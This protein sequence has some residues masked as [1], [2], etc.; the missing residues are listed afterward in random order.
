MNFYF[1]SL[2][3]AIPIFII[4][5]IVE[6]IFAKIKGIK[7]NRAADIISSQSSGMT[8]IIFDAL[9]FSIAIISYSWL[10]DK[11]AIIH[12]ELTW[13]SF[14]ITFLIID[15]A[16][17]WDHRLSH[18]INIL[19]NRH[20]IHH[21]SEDFNLSC[22]LRQSISNF[23]RFSSIFMIPAALLGI[24]ASLFAIIG[25]IHLFLQ[26]W[27]HT[28]LINKMGILEYIIVTP[29][30]HRV[31]HAINPEYID[32]NYS[33]IFIFWDKI[34]DT[35]QNELQNVKPVYGTLK[36]AKTWN[37]IFINFKHLKQLCLDS[38]RTK[39]I[40]DKFLIW[41]MPTGWRPKDVNK[42][43][44]LQKRNK[45]KY[46]TPMT[47]P[48]TFWSFFQLNIT[49][50]FLFHFLYTI[51]K[52]SY[53]MNYLYAILLLIHIFSFTS[54]LDM[55]MYSIFAEFMK[56]SLGF[57]ILITNN[58]IWFNLSGKFIYIIFFYSI[59]SLSLTI[60]FYLKNRTNNQ[61]TILT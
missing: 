61:F 48:L 38:W 41:I 7:I 46:E 32:K 10:V 9:K 56:I 18:R 37:P 57:F 34:F 58:Y 3:F 36:P 26:F 47:I 53:L 50:I 27:Y 24:P 52:N 14:V 59:I 17:Y 6:E 13:I 25:P 1:K 49:S 15:F 44:P 4:L 30:H 2:L 54:I 22:A 19:W 20:Y 35:F 29:S 11:L 5:I 39:N 43:F 55:K 42:S 33:Q 16:G 60:F 23:I 51:P 12:I 28:Q 21:S 8:N 45:K 31:H 40:K